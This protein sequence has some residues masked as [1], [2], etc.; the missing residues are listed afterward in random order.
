MPRLGKHRRLIAAFAAIYVLWGST[1]LAIALGVQSI[2]PFLL[3]AARSV[4]A[5][6]IL[7]GLSRSQGTPLPP[8]RAWRHAALGGVLLFAGCHGALAYAERYVPS[9]LAAIVLATIPFWMVLLQFLGP[10]GLRPRPASVAALLPGFAGVALITWRG[11]LSTGNSIDPLMIVILLGSAFSWALGSTIS[12][13]Q[14]VPVS[15]ICL[16]GMQL[17]CGGG[18]LL[19]ISALAGEWSNFALEQISGLSLAGLVY[20]TLAGSVLG[21]TAYV[22]LLGVVDGPTVATNTFVNPVIAVVL[23]WSLNGEDLTPTIVAGMALVIGSV[24]ALSRLSSSPLA[25]KKSPRLVG[26]FRLRYRAREFQSPPRSAGATTAQP[27]NVEP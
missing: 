23:G 26:P 5:G 16:S 17:L 11:A 6:I 10:V 12:R 14:T 2:P 20:L 25:D 7:L 22:W 24:V 4:L 9:G 3:M 8:A 1:Y 27:A 19:V 15:A 13:R 18:L 21:F